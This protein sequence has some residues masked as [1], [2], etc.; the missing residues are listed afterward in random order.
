MEK[1]KKIKDRRF[2]GMTIGEVCT[3]IALIGGIM[4]YT[5]DHFD[6]RFATIDQKLVSMDQKFTIRLD[7]VERRIGKVENRLNKLEQR[8]DRIEI[9]L[10]ST[11]GLLNNYLTWRFLYLHDPTRRNVEPRYDPNEKTLEFFNKTEKK[12]N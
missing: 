11:S 7:T 9:D 3:V 12:G 1:I 4:T 5:F 8:L 10:K 2:F 6:D